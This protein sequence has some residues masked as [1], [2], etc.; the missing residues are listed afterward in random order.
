VLDG[1]VPDGAGP[2][3]SAARAARS[4]GNRNPTSGENN[5]QNSGVCD[6]PR[7]LAGQKPNISATKAFENL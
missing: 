1:A 4:K 2:A 6:N 3:S 7:N 5:G